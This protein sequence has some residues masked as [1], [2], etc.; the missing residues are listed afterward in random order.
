MKVICNSGPLMALAKL[1][2][3]SL[4][5]KLYGE[6]TVPKE[7]YRESV[8]EG[9]N[10]GYEDARTIELFLNKQN[11]E[12]QKVDSKNID[13]ELTGLNLDRGEIEC[14]TLGE[15]SSDS[16]VLLDDEHAR[17]ICRKRGIKVKGTLG[18]LVEAYQKDLIS[19][20]DLDFYFEQIADRE[21][22]WINRE[23][24]EKVLQQLKKDAKGSQLG[25]H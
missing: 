23:L 20:A 25:S 2:L 1:N 14:I 4:L 9:K 11:W 17:N 7:V 15:T 22:I 21:D 12:P 10:K 18:V 3:L 16:M 8:T 13:R 5:K 6:V 24:C 19:L